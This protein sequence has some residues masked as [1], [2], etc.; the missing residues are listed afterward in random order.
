MLGLNNVLQ[1]PHALVAGE[2]GQAVSGVS[3][4]MMQNFRGQLVVLCGNDG[5]FVHKAAMAVFVL[6]VPVVFYLC[7]R[8]RLQKSNG[9]FEAVAALAIMIAI[10][11]SPHTHTQD[12][13]LLSVSGILLWKYLEEKIT[14]AG[15]L[16]QKAMRSILILFPALSWLFFYM[17][18]IFMFIRVQ[19]FFICLLLLSILTFCYIQFRENIDHRSRQSG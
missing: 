14:A 10:M 6:S 16:T 1:Y 18:P 7:M 19:A 5:S 3:S 2:T 17:H 4:F 9:S 12:Y 11:T 8:Y 13:V 15:V